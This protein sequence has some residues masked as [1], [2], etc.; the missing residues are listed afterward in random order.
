MRLWEGCEQVRVLVTGGAGFVGSHVVEQ[1][2]RRGDEVVVVDD[3]STG[4]A[5]NLP[6]RVPLQR[7]DIA[8]AE[9]LDEAFLG[10]RFDAVVHAAA[11]ASV[12]RS[13]AEPER[14][15]RI[16]VRGTA[17]V[18]ALARAVGAR[19][20]VFFSTG[21]AIYGETP[22]CA[23]EDAPA[24]PISPY[25]RHKLAAEGLV[26]ASGLAHAVLRPGNVYGPRQRGDL[27]AGV[28]AIFLQRY[29]AGKELVVYGDGGAE[30]DYV[31]AS[32]VAACTLVALDRPE[33][34]TWNVGTGVATSVNALVAALRRLLG[35]PKG[36]VRYA[37][38]RP[39]ELQRACV[40]PA[41]AA[42][43]LGW[44]ARLTFEGGLRRLVE[45]E[46]RTS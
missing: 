24:R 35:E 14:S 28:I 8:D 31:H 4:D 34:G 23:T 7:L 39:G 20:F 1:L 3:L 29:R 13:V 32:D 9:A 30:R 45:S 17:N 42:R 11:E 19:R 46:A 18:T 36:G 33:V 40:D 27:E 26:K 25:G 22:T 12:V 37:P 41:K 15:E 21:G 10:E 44:R 2:A 43:E 5:T 6:P 16:N 38:A